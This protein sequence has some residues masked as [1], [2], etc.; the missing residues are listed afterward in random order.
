MSINK[1]LAAICDH[2]ELLIFFQEKSKIG[3][4]A[5]GVAFCLL[6]KAL[7]SDAIHLSQISFAEEPKY[8]EGELE[9]PARGVLLTPPTCKTKFCCR[10]PTAKLSF[11]SQHP[12]SF[13]EKCS[14]LS[15]A[16]SSKGGE[17]DAQALANAATLQVK[18]P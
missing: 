15:P 18:L 14:L 6:V 3:G 10:L 12:R 9:Q 7:R 13:S 1:R 2:L 11:G 8:N 5:F 16:L 17:G 4:K